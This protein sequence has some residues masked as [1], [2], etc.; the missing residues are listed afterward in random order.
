MANLHS[1]GG[2]E[3]LLK[4]HLGV[5]RQTNAAQRWHLQTNA[6]QR[7]HLHEITTVTVL[8]KKIKLFNSPPMV[9]HALALLKLKSD[10]I[11]N[12]VC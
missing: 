6:A 12:I 3:T 2:T 7:W 4:W 9:R 1:R 5:F 11:C 10:N 8:G